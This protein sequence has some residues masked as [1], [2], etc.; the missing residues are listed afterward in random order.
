MLHEWIATLLQTWFTWVEQW[1]YWGIFIL[2][3]MESS[4]I[5]VPSEV[6]LPP[7]AFWAA[8]GRFDFTGVVLAA[9]AGSYVGSI[10][11]YGVSLA[12]GRPLV[13]RYGRLVFL[14]PSKLAVAE[15][16]VERYGAG[17]I[18]FARLLPVVRHLVSIPAGVLRMPIWPFSFATIAGAAL[19][20][21]ILTWF[22]HHV[23]GDQPQLL[24]SPQVMMEAVRAKMHWLVIGIG[25]FFALYAVSVYMRRRLTPRA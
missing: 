11:S 15:E 9:V 5:P 21:V 2:M 7:A 14:P 24:S 17:G 6:V 13:H 19:W 3:A 1:G 8:Q 25:A 16:W 12:I 23:L 10:I 4:I 18:F 22:G 20:C